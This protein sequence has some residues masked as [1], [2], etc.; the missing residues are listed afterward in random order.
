M[1]KGKMLDP[2]DA[3]IERFD[4]NVVGT[5]DY[6]DTADSDVVVVTAGMPQAGMSRDDLIATNVQ[7][8]TVAEQVAKHSQLRHDCISNPRCHGVHRMESPI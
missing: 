2:F 8:G 3:P 6:A 4:A 7:S 5:A 1:V